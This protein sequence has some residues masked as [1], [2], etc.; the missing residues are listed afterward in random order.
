MLEL[1]VNSI[2]SAILTN[3]ELIKAIAQEKYEGFNLSHG[4]LQS[5]AESGSGPLPGM[6]H[7]GS[8]FLTELNSGC[9]V[10]FWSQMPARPGY[11]CVFLFHFWSIKILIL[12]MDTSFDVLK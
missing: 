4:M 2:I 10:C 12:F 11:S 3:T 6:V 5:G 1:I 8:C 9:L 7:L